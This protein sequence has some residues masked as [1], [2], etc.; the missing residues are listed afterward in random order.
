MANGRKIL[1][2]SKAMRKA[3]KAMKAM[4]D[5]MK[6]IKDAFDPA[7]KDLVVEQEGNEGHAG[8]ERHAGDEGHAVDEVN[9]G[10]E[11][12]EKWLAIETV[13]VREVLLQAWV[14]DGQIKHKLFKRTKAP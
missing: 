7:G 3:K 8:D 10:N 4:K 13:G 1:K 2:K 12:L 6:A 11:Y 5:A 9:E 14:E